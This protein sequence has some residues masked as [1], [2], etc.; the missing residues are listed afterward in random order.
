MP[1][2]SNGLT[3]VDVLDT[4]DSNDIACASLFCFYTFQT[5]ESEQFLNTCGLARTIT[6]NYG[7]RLALFDNTAVNTSYRNTTQVIVVIH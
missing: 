3:N 1:R 5:L 7:Y 2:V 6:H 4:C